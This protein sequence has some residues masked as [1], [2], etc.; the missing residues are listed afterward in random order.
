M[1]FVFLVVWTKYEDV[2]ENDKK[3]FLITDFGLRIIRC[4]ENTKKLE[5]PLCLQG[6]PQLFILCNHKLF[7]L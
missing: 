5:E 7:T 6:F 2:L 3:L 1:I 4:Q